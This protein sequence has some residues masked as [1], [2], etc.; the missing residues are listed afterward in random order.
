M[1][2][3][4]RKNSWRKNCPTSNLYLY[5][6]LYLEK[7]FLKNCYEKLLEGAAVWKLP[8]KRPV[9]DYIIESQRR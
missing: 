8:V 3:S 5:L 4:A 7:L 1:I 9:S 6:Y 2:I